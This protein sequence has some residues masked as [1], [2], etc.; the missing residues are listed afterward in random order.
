MIQQRN[1]DQKYEYMNTIVKLG[2]RSSTC[3]SIAGK[4]CTA[5]IV[6]DDCSRKID[7]RRSKLSGMLG[8][9]APTVGRLGA[10][11]LLHRPK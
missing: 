6:R 7:R 3:G 1:V 9:S 8:T 4:A 11:V 10:G 5:N 2:S